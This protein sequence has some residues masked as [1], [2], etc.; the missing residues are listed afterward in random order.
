M[1]LYYL[2]GACSLVPHVAL[3]WIG[4]PYEAIETS[5]ELIKSPDYLALNPLGLVPL[6]V[7][8]DF[9]LSQNIASRARAG[10]CTGPV[11]V[12]TLQRLRWASGPAQPGP[13][14]PAV[15]VALSAGRRYYR[16]HVDPS[17]A[18]SRCP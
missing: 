6:L 9:V 8:D 12:R 1:K 18:L 16:P 3:A 13:L 5:Y 2:K 15:V 11:A 14:R 17:Y 7:D 4:K 10:A